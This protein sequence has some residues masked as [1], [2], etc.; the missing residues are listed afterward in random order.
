RLDL[1]MAV[2]QQEAEGRLIGAIPSAIAQK[3]YVFL[4]RDGR[5]QSTAAW[6]S[7]NLMAASA[8]LAADVNQDGWMDL[9]FAADKVFL[10]YGQA[11][12]ERPGQAVPIAEK[13]DWPST[14]RTLFAATLDAGWIGSASPAAGEPL[15]LAA[16]SICSVTPTQA[17]ADCQ[18]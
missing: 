8:V 15:T 6:R 7:Q 11:P 13:A 14:Q 18:N 10:Y 4:N 2:Y 3:S 5:I 12:G 17:S 1:V 16:S 9:A